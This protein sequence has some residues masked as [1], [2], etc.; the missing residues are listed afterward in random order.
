M[1]SETVPVTNDNTLLAELARQPGSAV[2]QLAKRVTVQVRGK[3]STNDDGVMRVEV[4]TG[5][6]SVMIETRFL[7]PTPEQ[8]RR[9]G[10]TVHV[11]AQPAPVR[12]MP[13]W[14]SQRQ[15]LVHA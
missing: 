9:L 14:Q 7:A 5:S 12:A 8:A 11:Q 15:D 10:I 4:L 2:R 1:T 6:T 3:A 13:S